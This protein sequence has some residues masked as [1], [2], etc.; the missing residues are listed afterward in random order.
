MPGKKQA[1]PKLC[2]NGDGHAAIA[3]SLCRSCYS[4]AKWRGEFDPKKHGT[5]VTAFAAW[6]DTNR[7]APDGQRLCLY[8]CPA[9]RKDHLVSWAEGDE[10]PGLKMATCGIA[11]AKSSKIPLFN[12]LRPAGVSKSAPGGYEVR[13]KDRDRRRDPENTPGLSANSRVLG[14]MAQVDFQKDDFPERLDAAILR[15]RSTSPVQSKPAD[16][17]VAV[18]I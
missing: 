3:H 14:A 18:T 1:A 5:P 10:H 16:S 7:N 9:C 12:V 17:N 13:S 6:P 4:K 2:S 11:T 15:G 8:R